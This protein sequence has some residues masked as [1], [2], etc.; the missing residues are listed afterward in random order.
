MAILDRQTATIVMTAVRAF[1]TCALWGVNATLNPE[2]GLAMW[3]ARHETS[4]QTHPWMWVLIRENGPE[5]KR[6]RIMGRNAKEA[7]QRMSECTRAAR[8][9]GFGGDDRFKI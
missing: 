5:C 3:L 1:E 2:T 6:V 4:V 9:W 7:K 8:D